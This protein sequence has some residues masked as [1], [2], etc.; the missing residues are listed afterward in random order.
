MPSSRRVT[1]ASCRL[2][3][4]VGR[5]RAHALVLA[6]LGCPS[7]EML[8]SSRST[9]SAAMRATAL[10]APHSRCVSGRLPAFRRPH[11]SFRHDAPHVFLVDRHADRAVGPQAL[12]HAEAQPSRRE[13]RRKL[14]REVELVVTR[15][16][17]HLEHVAKPFVVM[18]RF[19]RRRA[20]SVYWSRASSR[21]R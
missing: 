16:R 18:S 4:G 10:R 15:S 7:L 3:V 9:F 8:T 12:A 11:S 6:D 13:R 1:Y 2:H 19:S 21:A 14:E 17:P 20:R 5:G